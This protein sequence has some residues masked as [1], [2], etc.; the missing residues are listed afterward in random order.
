LNR[1]NERPPPFPSLSAFHGIRVAQRS[2]P[3]PCWK[4]CKKTLLF[5]RITTKSCNSNP[6]SLG[7]S[8][9]TLTLS[10]PFS[11]LLPAP[12]VPPPPPL[13]L[14]LPPPLPL[15]PSSPTTSPLLKFVAGPRGALKGSLD[16]GGGGWR[17]REASIRHASG[18][19]RV[20][21]LQ[22]QAAHEVGKAP[23]SFGSRP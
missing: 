21:E 14:R 7:R 8:A 6:N 20:E 5:P 15:P 23:V 19:L 4:F 11:R 9:P 22:I 10:R 2:L 13:P 1:R 17:S 12:R 3:R 16:F 18:L